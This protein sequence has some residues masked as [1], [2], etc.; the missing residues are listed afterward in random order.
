VGVVGG[1]PLDNPG[2]KIDRRTT[3]PLPAVASD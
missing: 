2:Q 3:T 1:T